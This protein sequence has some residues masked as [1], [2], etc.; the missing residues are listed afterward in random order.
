LVS[1]DPNNSIYLSQEGPLIVLSAPRVQN[2]I[3]ML[4]G[5]YTNSAQSDLISPEGWKITCGR[6]CDF[7]NTI[8][9]IPY[10]L[11]TK[12]R[13]LQDGV[14]P[15]LMSI[16]LTQIN[17]QAMLLCKY[18]YEL[19]TFGYNNKHKS[20]SYTILY[21]QQVTLPENDA[22]VFPPV[23]PLD[24]APKSISDSSVGYGVDTM[25]QELRDGFS[26]VCAYRTNNPE[27][28]E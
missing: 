7:Q 10:D 23:L 25:D 4:Q 24:V 20:K 11:S 18:R 12:Q 15:K 26:F 28:V 1:T 13:H 27:D 2:V 17:D 19:L 21:N 5:Q 9:G 14:H 16:S 22:I 6:S 3:Q 8:S